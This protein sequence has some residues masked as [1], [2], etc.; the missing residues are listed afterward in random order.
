MAKCIRKHESPIFGR[1]HIVPMSAWDDGCLD[2]EVP[3]F[4]EFDD[5]GGGSFQLSLRPM[6]ARL[7][8][9]HAARL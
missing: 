7:P 6:E 5:K 9:D 8:Q 4:I 2:E 1:W 3:A